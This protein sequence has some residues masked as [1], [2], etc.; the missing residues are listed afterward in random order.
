MARVV[1]FGQGVEREE[2]AL[3]DF[4]VWRLRSEECEGGGDVD[5]DVVAARCGGAAEEA[6]QAQGVCRLHDDLGLLPKLSNHGVDGILAN[7]DATPGQVP[8]L[9]ISMAHEADAA[10]SVEGDAPHAEGH[11]TGHEGAELE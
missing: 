3:R 6:M 11:S 10:L 2:V 1:S 5:S 9:H 7:L 4:P 8:S